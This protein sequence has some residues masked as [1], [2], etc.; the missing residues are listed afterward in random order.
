MIQPNTGSSTNVLEFTIISDSGFVY[1][2]FA[3]G[4]DTTGDNWVQCFDDSPCAQGKTCNELCLEYDYV[5]C[6]SPMNES[7]RHG[8]CGYCGEGGMCDTEQ[9][10]PNFDGCYHN[11]SEETWCSADLNINVC[12]QNN[13]G[14]HVEQW[15]REQ[16][17]YGCDNSFCNNC[18]WEYHITPEGVQIEVP[19]YNCGFDL[20][21]DEGGGGAP[22]RPRNEPGVNT[23]YAQGGSVKNVNNTIR[24]QGQ[25]K[26]CPPG[27]HWTWEGPPG[28]PGG[29]VPSF[30]LDTWI[31]EGDL[32]ST[33][34]PKPR[35]NHP[36][37]R[38]GNY[39]DNGCI[40][41]CNGYNYSYPGW[42]NPPGTW[43]DCQVTG[44]DCIRTDEPEAHCKCECEC[45][46]N[47][48]T[49]S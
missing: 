42:P 11:S 21:P 25:M 37:C 20:D 33:M 29:C 47:P 3:C 4:D 5:F 16:Y 15:V 18:C 46:S 12:C 44:Y 27:Q 39:G 8:I 17:G 38:N 14:N 24:S 43:A 28:F 13:C 49:P 45:N 6:T 31:I 9:T 7:A 2:G 1:A 22:I 36:I 48:W 23:M 34:C 35:E 40:Q 10:D 30:D 41:W 32:T 19:A 26:P